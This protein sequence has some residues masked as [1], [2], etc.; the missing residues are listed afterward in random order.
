MN[1]ILFPE[2]GRSSSGLPVTLIGWGCENNY[3]P[4]KNPIY[5]S[6]LKEANF[7]IYDYDLCA[8]FYH[9]YDVLL[10]WKQLCA[11]PDN[12]HENVAIVNIFICY[13][14]CFLVKKTI[15]I[16]CFLLHSR[17]TVVIL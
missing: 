1:R 17:E 13:K 3:N 2:I 11:I 16:V 5:S 9:Q 8:K 15:I 6:I 10:H 4:D 14:K 7:K 12:F